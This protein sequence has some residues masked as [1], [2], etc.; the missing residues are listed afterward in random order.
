MGS[1]FT[2]RAYGPTSNSPL[3]LFNTSSTS[4][5]VHYAGSGFIR[6]VG[7]SGMTVENG[8]GQF[9]VTFATPVAVA[10]DVSRITLESGA[11]TN[12]SCVTESSCEL[13]G[14][15]PGG[16]VIFYYSATPFTCGVAR[17]QSCN[18]LEAAPDG[19]NGGSDPTLPACYG[20]GAGAREGSFVFGE[21]AYNSVGLI[22]GCYD[23]YG[24]GYDLNQT[25][26][27]VADRYSN[28]G[29]S[30]WFIPSRPE[31]HELCKYARGQETGNTSVKC[32][33]TGTL[34]SG[35]LAAP[36]LSSSTAEAMKYRH[37]IWFDSAGETYLH[38]YDAQQ[39]VRPIRAF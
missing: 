10:G 35:F 38:G 17:S 23:R 15:G 25:A 8:S 36:Y 39:A 19:W 12:F 33:S 24:I 14:T 13:L 20:S 31:L 6:G 11:H 30:D 21:G 7:G 18:Y 27:K 9:T 26:D 16:G 3:P 5:V 1:D 22:T 2:I 28:A 37:D 29:Y 34:K 4:A 32:A